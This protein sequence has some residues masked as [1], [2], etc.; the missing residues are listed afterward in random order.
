MIDV[1][2]PVILASKSPR[3]RRLLR[4]I[5]PEFGVVDPRIDETQHLAE[6][7]REIAR[8]LACAKARK[9]ARERPDCCVIAA[10]TLVECAGEILG[11]PTDRADAIRM[12]NKLCSTP[13]RIMTGLCVVMP[14]GHEHATCVSVRVVMRDLHPGEIEDYVDG[15]DVMGRAGAYGLRELDPNVEQIDGSRSAVMGLPLEKL[16]CILRSCTVKEDCDQRPAYNT[17]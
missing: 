11:K 17:N 4:K 5:V 1:E 7:P 15:H 10:D 3:R 6:T 16:G 2:V 9:V 13:H 12:L 8:E 14:D